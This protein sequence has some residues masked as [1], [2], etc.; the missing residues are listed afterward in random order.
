MVS[1]P[2]EPNHHGVVRCQFD[3]IASR[4]AL[5]R[6]GNWLGTIPSHFTTAFQ[7]E[8]ISQRGYLYLCKKKGV[9]ILITCDEAMMNGRYSWTVEPG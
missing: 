7:W 4:E 6:V 2:I 1:Q 9:V 8:V 3:T 5:K